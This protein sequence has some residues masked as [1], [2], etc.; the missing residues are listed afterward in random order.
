MTEP[1]EQE[2]VALRGGGAPRRPASIPWRW[3]ASPPTSR[4]WAR[5][6]PS[7]TTCGPRCTTR[8]RWFASPR[9]RTRLAGCLDVPVLELAGLNLDD[10]VGAACASR[11]RE[12]A[13]KEECQRRLDAIER[14]ARRR[15]VDRCAVPAGLR[16]PRNG[17][18]AADPPA[19]RPWAA[20]VT[21]GR[22]RHR[23]A[24]A[25]DRP[26]RRRPLH[27]RAVG[28]A[29][30]RRP[31]PRRRRHGHG[32]TRRGRGSPVNGTRDRTSRLTLVVT[33]S[34]RRGSRSDT[35]PA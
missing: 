3:S 17:A 16:T 34:R 12:L 1:D 30:A 27:R 35:D 22:R 10:L 33:H 31:R 11:D 32:G 13:L 29:R 15:G 26:S 5:W 25:P 4:P 24:P 7:S 20:N 28:G 14:R 21:R 9:T 23:C 8:P 18:R 19:G 6:R 2:L